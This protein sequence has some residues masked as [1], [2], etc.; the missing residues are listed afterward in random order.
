MRST[1][2]EIPPLREAMSEPNMDCEQHRQKNNHSL[3]TRGILRLH[4]THRSVCVGSLTRLWLVAS[5][6]LC[7]SADVLFLRR[8]RDVSDVRRVAISAAALDGVG[9]PESELNHDAAWLPALFTVA[10]RTVG[11]QARRP[12]TTLA[13]KG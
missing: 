5:G 10:A 9:A 2:G 13:N 3:D 4:L 11:G 1:P 6:L 8:Q 7:V 12:E